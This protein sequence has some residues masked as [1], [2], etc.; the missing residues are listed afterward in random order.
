MATTKFWT[1]FGDTII[2]SPHLTLAA[3][4]G[5]APSIAIANERSVLFPRTSDFQLDPAYDSNPHKLDLDEQSLQSAFF[6]RCLSVWGGE[7]LIRAVNACSLLQC[8]HHSSCST[9]YKSL[10]NAAAHALQAMVDLPSPTTHKVAK[11]V[12]LKC[13]AEDRRF[14]NDPDTDEASEVWYCL[15]APWCGLETALGNLQ[16]RPDCAMQ[17]GAHALPCGQNEHS[18]P[19]HTVHPMHS[20]EQSSNRH[21]LRGRLTSLQVDHGQSPP[22][23]MPHPVPQCRCQVTLKWVVTARGMDADCNPVDPAGSRA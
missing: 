13:Q 18:M 9:K 5:H 4:L 15:G 22:A 2:A 12:L 21:S 16:A 11:A 20:P 1:R 8:L 17:P 10:R 6:V 23:I 14:E 19:Q 3:F 7:A